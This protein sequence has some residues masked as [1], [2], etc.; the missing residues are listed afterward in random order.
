MEGKILREIYDNNLNQTMRLRQ[1]IDGGVFFTSIRNNLRSNDARNTQRP[2]LA[3]IR[4][5]DRCNLHC[6]YCYAN[7]NSSARDL[8]REQFFHIVDLCE[9]NGI[10]G[11]TWTGGEPFLSE[12]FPEL[13]V[14]T[15]EYGI[16]QTI[17]TNGT[18]LH[19]L[20]VTNIPTDNLNIQVSL[21]NA[22]S[23]NN[24]N[25]EILR[26]AATA[27]QNGYD[28]SLTILL[29]CVELD[30]YQELLENIIEAGVPSVRFGIKMPIGAAS[31]DDM[32]TYRHGIYQLIPKLSSLRDKYKGRLKIA[33]QFD[34]SLYQD[35]GLPRRF[36]MCE[37]GT[38]QIFIDNNG[39]VYPCPMLKSFKNLYCGN[40]LTHSWE[41]LWNAYPM[42]RMRNIEECVGCKYNCKVWCRALKYATDFD[43][44]GK[45][46]F[47][48]NGI[49]EEMT[50]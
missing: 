35:T 25:T 48:L 13:V 43:F 5:T 19:K 16:R 22:W 40:I 31:D 6:S 7:D 30:L 29:E 8:T 24:Q 42:I 21:N 11:I 20:Y 18:F 36:L 28:V 32:A 37:A 2:I 1:N 23:P 34:K 4:V 39:D 47:C 50:V 41:Q 33:Y 45:S 12:V 46:Y 26:N 15:H 9:K 49:H 14:Y 3:H 17:L 44:E 27:T 10:L 38:T